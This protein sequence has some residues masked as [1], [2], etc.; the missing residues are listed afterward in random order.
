MF[1]PEGHLQRIIERSTARVITGATYD[2]CSLALID[3]LSWE[4]PDDRWHYGKSILMYK[5]LN[6]Y[7]THRLLSFSN[8]F[9]TRNV[10]Q[11]NQKGM[12]F[13]VQ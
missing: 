3:S 12:E 8:S 9:V 1:F 13:S 11:V 2:I 10:D 4:T 6:D 7:T 5:I